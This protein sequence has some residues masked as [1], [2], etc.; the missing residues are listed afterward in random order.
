M[1]MRDPRTSD[2]AQDSDEAFR[3]EIRSFLRDA[4]PADIRAATRAHCLVT[5]EQ[6]AR[7]HR[8]LHAQGWAAPGWPREHGG[9]GWS[10]VRQAI[11]R[12][13]LAASDAPYIENLGIDTIG[14]T[15]IRHGTDEQCRRFLPGMLSFDDFWAQGYSEPDAGS[16][17]AA[18]RT[19]ARREGD[20]WIVN[21]SKIWQ[22]LGHWANWALLLVRT[23]PAASRKQDGISI[24]LVDLRTPG[25]TVRPIRYINGSHF[26]V[27][28]FFDDVRVPAANLVGE[29]NGGWAIAKGLLVIERLFVARVAECKAELARAAAL[30][31][32][33][34]DEGD[35]VMRGEQQM[36]FALTARRHAALDIR[37]RAL[38]AAWWPA[39]Q[40]AAEGGRPDLEASLLKLEG[41]QL[42]QDLQ[43]F[44]MDAHG[45]ASLR[46]YPEALDGQPPD[47]PDDAAS[48]GNQTLHMWRYRGSSLAGGSSE[49]QRQIIAKSIFDGQTEL[50]VPRND[51]LGD[52]QAMM[53]DTM[54]RWLSKHYSF[55]FRQQVMHT[56]GGCSA[57][58]W[59]GLAELGITSLTIPEALG[60]MEQP[61]TD[62]LPLMETLGEALVLEP[63]PWS[64]VFGTQ[65]LLALPVGPSRDARLAALAG[66]D[67]RCAVLCGKEPGVG[68]TPQP[69]VI[70][71][72]VGDAWQ[73]DGDDAMVMGGTDAHHFI[74]AATLD[75]GSL[76]LFDL[77]ADASGVVVQGYRFHDGRS[78][79]E[80][81]LTNVRLSAF[82]MLGQDE[83]AATALDR[84]MTFA[85]L[86]LC[87]DS[88]GA[89]RRALG[90]T[91]E[92]LRTRRQFG[93]TLAEQ[94][95]LQHRMADH[96]RAWNGARHL[97]RRVLVD[98]DAA[99]SAERRRRICAAKHLSGVV[100]RAIAFDVLQLHGAIGLQDETPISHYSKRLVGNDLLLGS[101]DT[102]L[103]RFAAAVDAIPRAPAR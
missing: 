91:A 101:A 68:K 84:G 73:L 60:G 3:A 31:H 48:A 51:H 35:P 89:M 92:Y 49:I 39:I 55:D 97:A 63:V 44:R 76:G 28:M 22:S 58:A 41:I 94:Q 83:Q 93:R 6:A 90:I 50:D 96:F 77:P 42:L 27:Q 5:R 87:A 100:G 13:E 88:I 14:P 72:R 7:W 2:R 40:Q 8:I 57:S 36:A 74:V 61:M 26:H 66:G 67:A 99:P 46:L 56:P 95:V 52:E 78:A 80:V 85:T 102:H 33:P 30:L 19:T 69:T 1:T 64:A 32:P 62:L 54:R 82:A 20:C 59:S 81:L 15:L 9:T 34:S 43:L 23:D 21:G 71:R 38:E 16:D 24:L 86:A 103:G 11:F 53:V 18:L 37:M 45:T 4:V 17:L 25:V 29:P 10:L 12:E 70:A 98:W 79:A 75:D 65:T 47:V